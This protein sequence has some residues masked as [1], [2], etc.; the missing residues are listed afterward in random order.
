MRLVSL[1]RARGASALVGG[2]SFALTLPTASAQEVSPLDGDRPPTSF[3]VSGDD[4][5]HWHASRPDSHAPIGVMADHVHAAG[6]WMVSLRYMYMDMG[7]NRDGTRNL[8]PQDVLDQGWMVT[9]TEMTMEMWMLGAMYAP[10][11]D[12]TLMAMLPYV[13]KE[14]DHVTGMGGQFTTESAGIGD[15]RLSALVPYYENEGGTKA[16]LEAGISL[17]TGSIDERDDT[18]MGPNR[19]LPYPMQIGTGTL[20]LILGSTVQHQFE[21]TSIGGQARG[22]IQLGENDEGYTV[23]DTLDASLWAAYKVTDRVSVSSRLAYALWSDYDGFDDELPPPTSMVIPTAR[24]DLRGGQRVD[25]GLGVNTYLD[26]RWRIA[27][28]VLWPVY[29]D[30]DGPQLETDL[31]LVAGFQVSF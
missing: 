6:E 15:V 27:A 26:R 17:P 12:L 8:S 29:Q 2:L 30:L 16:H 25:Y 31:T 7:G 11:D 5:G 23:G 1:R 3:T 10:S 22:G 9:P 20:G 14:M 13:E 19:T 21:R 4:H 18:P 28:E 24:P